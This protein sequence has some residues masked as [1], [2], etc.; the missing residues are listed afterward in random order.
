[1][2]YDRILSVFLPFLHR[3]S[4]VHG[5]IPIEIRLQIIDLTYVPHLMLYGRIQCRF[6]L[7]R[8]VHRQIHVFYR[9]AESLN[10][11]ADRL[12]CTINRL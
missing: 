5:R 7:T 2:I 10:V 3:I 6:F 12:C 9:L 8:Y 4:S 11:L 1:M